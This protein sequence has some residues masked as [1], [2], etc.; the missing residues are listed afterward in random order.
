[1]VENG[2]ALAFVAAMGFAAT[3]LVYA[4]RKSGWPSFR[5]W[6]DAEGLPVFMLTCTGLAILALCSGC[7]HAL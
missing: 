2:I 6:W 7:F 3:L 1:M 5:Q 4:Y